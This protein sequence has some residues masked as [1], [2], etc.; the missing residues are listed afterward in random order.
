MTKTKLLE[1]LAFAEIAHTG[2]ARKGTGEP[3]INHPIRVAALVAAHGGSEE[4]V[5]AA[6]LHDVVEDTHYTA[7]HV[8]DLF[9]HEV[10]KIVV[11]LTSPGDDSEYNA[12]LAAGGS[13]V[14]LVKA[15]D[16]V[17]NTANA[18]EALGAY[19]STY[20]KKKAITLA[21]LTKA[22]ESLV[23]IAKGNIEHGNKLLAV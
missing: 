17:D 7:E 6:Y 15:A 21:L 20:L 5:I 19:A 12:L 8:A 22:P 16:I 1:A 4:A 14:H 11:G 3:Y 23:L 13:D 2:A 18:A 10:A 9:G